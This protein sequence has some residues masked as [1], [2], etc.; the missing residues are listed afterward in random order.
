LLLALALCAAVS[1]AAVP[2]ASAHSGGQ[3]ITVERVQIRLE[4]RDWIQLAVC[5]GQGRAA[6]PG[7]LPIL[8]RYKHFG[9]VLFTSTGDT[10]C[11]RVHVLASGRLRLGTLY[12]GFDPETPSWA[13]G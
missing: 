9:C 13:C 7:A 10:L 6:N 2:T 11:A 4:R 12:D 8:R 1:A 3:Y 5:A